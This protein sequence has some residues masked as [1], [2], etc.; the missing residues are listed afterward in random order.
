M[1]RKLKQ[2]F[3][4]QAVSRV[5]RVL[6]LAEAPVVLVCRRWSTTNNRAWRPCLPGAGG[7]NWCAASA[8]PS[9]PARNRQWP[10]QNV[11]GRPGRL[12]GSAGPGQIEQ[13]VQ[14]GDSR[15]LQYLP[16]GADPRGNI[17]RAAIWI[18]HA[19]EELGQPI[20]AQGVMQPIVVRPIAGGRYESSPVNAAG[21]PASRPVEDKIPAVVREVPD[22][23]RLP[24]R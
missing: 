5:I 1:S 2:H 4:R 3:R 9:R 6:R 14:T 8:T 24:W 15:E 18:H 19:L 7:V 16:L 10:W 12:L 21:V 17:S 20:R 11:A 22:E 23:A 13:H